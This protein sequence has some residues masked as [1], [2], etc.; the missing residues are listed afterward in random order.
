M[1]EERCR[2]KL[3]AKELRIQQKADDRQVVAEAALNWTNSRRIN[4]RAN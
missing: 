2:M 4:K 3:A 1:L